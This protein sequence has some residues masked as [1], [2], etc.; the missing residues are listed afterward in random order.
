MS[1]TRV[2]SAAA[3]AAVLS[4]V[5]GTVPARAADV[6]LGVKA[7]TLGFGLD[8]TGRLSDRLNVRAGLH[9]GPSYTHTGRE[10]DIEYEFDVQLLSAAAGLDWHPGGSGFH[11]SGGFVLNRNEIDAA[12]RPTATY[13]IGGRTY[14]PAQTGSLLGTLN[15]K[16]VAPYA[17]L[18]FGNPV[19]PGKKLGVVL[20]LGLVFAGSPRVE[21]SAT[22]PVAS[23]PQ[24]QRDL[25]A[26]ERDFE[27]EISQ[28]K[29]YPLVSFAVTY[30][31]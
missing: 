29:I 28:F 30:R 19:S 11:F 16:D 25:E 24:F 31:F 20:D 1:H 10:S 9:P 14:T 3:V 22:G 12:A 13:E 21:L 6:A 8:L 23:D 4:G 18:G 5:A 17:G 2:L 15:F 27:E 26:E 7:S